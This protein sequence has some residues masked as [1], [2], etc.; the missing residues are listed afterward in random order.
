MRIQSLSVAL[1]SVASLP[2]L[3]AA[4]L[5]GCAVPRSAPPAERFTGEYTVDYVNGKVNSRFRHQRGRLVDTVILYD[6]DGSVGFRG[7]C[8]RA[9]G[10]GPS[11]L[12]G[13]YVVA[14]PDLLAAHPGQ[15]EIRAALEEARAAAQALYHRFQ[16]EWD[17]AGQVELELWINPD[18]HL[19]HV[20][21]LRDTTGDTAFV[22]AL[23][24]R[25]AEWSPVA[26]L[27]AGFRVVRLPLEFGRPK[28]LITARPGPSARG[29]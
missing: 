5:L 27:P 20:L 19:Q 6:V 13:S 21:C 3:A 17:I 28:P 11:R 18:G 1:L 26:P 14:A 25:M 4:A 10:A 16:Q 9:D 12:A 22:A 15:A 7:V 29:G 24:R 23:I 8:S 2:V